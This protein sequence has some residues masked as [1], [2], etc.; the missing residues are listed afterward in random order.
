ML[1]TLLRLQAV[2]YIVTGV[3]PL[4]SLRSFEWVTG[5]KVD[6]W[7]VHMVGL[8]AATIGV[9][10]WAGARANRPAD[11]MVLLSI[12]SATSFAFIDVRYASIGRIAPI[13]LGD[14]IV[15]V[16]LAA[17]VMMAWYRDHK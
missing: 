5:P 16:L 12:M 7:L 3:W 6:E 9:T 11:P 15:E 4:L 17:L 10:L 8:L 2:Y 13:Y 14:A 1:R